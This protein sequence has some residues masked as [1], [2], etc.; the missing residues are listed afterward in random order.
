MDCSYCYL[1]DRTNSRHT[2]DLST[3]TEVARLIFTSNLLKRDLD[4][5]WHAG[6]PLTLAPTYYRNAISIIENARPPGMAVHYG[7]QTN[8]H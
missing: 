5:V 2:M 4:I 7:L 8:G 6:E 3:V 1:P